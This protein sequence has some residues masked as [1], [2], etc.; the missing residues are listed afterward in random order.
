MHDLLIANSRTRPRQTYNGGKGSEDSQQ[1][2][3]ALLQS[4]F[5]PPIKRQEMFILFTW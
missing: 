3:L 1:E 4:T 5:T 2:T